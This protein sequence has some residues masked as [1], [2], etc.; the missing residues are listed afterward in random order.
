M[1]LQ[2]A[3]DLV[4]TIDLGLA[5]RQHRLQGGGI[6]RE[7]CGR[8]AHDSIQAYHTK[9]CQREGSACGDRDAGLARVM[10][11]P[12]VETFQERL[13]L[14]AVGLTTPSAMPASR[15]YRPPASSPA[16]TRRSRRSRRA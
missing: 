8:F 12:P 4:Q 7:A 14:R 16:G 6:I 2:L 1:A 9:V 5:R 11:A 15:T 3:D 13:Q 10:D